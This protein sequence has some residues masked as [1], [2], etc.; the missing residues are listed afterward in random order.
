MKATRASTYNSLRVQSKSLSGGKI[1]VSL[2][3]GKNP[4]R[5]ISFGGL[6][7]KPVRWHVMPKYPFF[8]GVAFLESAIDSL[9]DKKYY[10]T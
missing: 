2:I 4:R 6:R 9:Q 1:E 10:S 8:P 7:E 3:V 5:G